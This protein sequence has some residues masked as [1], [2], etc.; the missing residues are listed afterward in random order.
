MIICLPFLLFHIYSIQHLINDYNTIVQNCTIKENV[1][2]YIGGVC[3]DLWSIVSDC[4]ITSNSAKYTGGVECGYS[5]VRNCNI[6]YNYAEQRAG[7]IYSACGG[8]VQD[9][10]I[11]GNLVSNYGAG[12]VRI[13][14]D[15]V[16]ENCIISNNSVKGTYEYNCGGVICIGAATVK[17][18]LINGNFANNN[19]GV[20]CEDEGANLNCTKVVNW[21]NHYFVGIQCSSNSTVEN[22]I[23]WNNTNGNS[24]ADGSINYYN[25]IEN[26]TNIVNG[27]ITNNPEFIDAAAGNYRLESF[28]PCINAGT[29]MSW[30]LTATDLDGNPRIIDGIVDMG[31]YEYI[32]EPIT[33]FY[34]LLWA[35]IYFTKRSWMLFCFT[36]YLCIWGVFY[37]VYS[38]FNK[39]VST[40]QF[41]GY[42]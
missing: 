14:C 31:A 21:V 9:C 33:I 4:V 19:C 12:G 41:I 32:P 40:D 10:I 2:K 7:G 37:A 13:G 24:F 18:C 39:G 15:S 25:C 42:V 35:V 16:I 11:N 6:S 22:C 23:L 1:A 38:L 36:G 20:L 8:I 3:C 17:V 34:L 27:I 30:M 29:N 28:S 26:W 5:I